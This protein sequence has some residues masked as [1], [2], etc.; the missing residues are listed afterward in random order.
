VTVLATNYQAALKVLSDAEVHFVII[1]MYAAAV[2]GS[3]QMTADLDIYYERTPQNLKRLAK[4]L[5]PYHPVLRGAPKGLPFVLDE[6]TLSRGMN[7]TLETDLGDIDLIG[8]LSALGQFHEVA[9][10][11]VC[12]P[13]FGGSYRVASLDAVIRS[14]RAAG[15]PKDL[16]SL[17]ELEALRDLNNLRAKVKKKL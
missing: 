4:A 2:Q 7:F 5:A 8:D 1:G 15:R 12:L 10:D 17:P 16:N 3:A 14:K 6:T 9:A 11:S 13:L